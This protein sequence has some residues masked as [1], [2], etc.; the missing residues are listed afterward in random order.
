MIRTRL[1]SGLGLCL[2]FEVLA[3][4]PR[5]AFA[6]CTTV[7]PSPAVI[8]ATGGV[9]QWE[10]IQTNT[11]ITPEG[12]LEQGC[13]ITVIASLTIPVVSAADLS[14][15]DNYTGIPNSGFITETDPNITFP[16]TGYIYKVNVA[17]NLGPDRFL[18]VGAAFFDS[19]GITSIQ[20]G[21]VIQKGLGFDLSIA[22]ISISQ[23]NQLIAPDSSGTFPLSVGIEAAVTLQINGS[24][25][26]T[27][28]SRTTSV[29]FSVDGHT[30]GSIPL[31]LADL[32]NA[33]GAMKITVPAIP[34]GAG[35]QRWSAIV[36]PGNAQNE[37]D[38][39]NNLASTFVRVGSKYEV[40]AS[41]KGAEIISQGPPLLV[42]V[43]PSNLRVCSLNS[44]PFINE[45]LVN[46]KCNDKITGA[47]ISGCKFRVVGSYPSD[48]YDGGHDRL[49]HPARPLQLLYKE[50]QS[51]YQPIPVEGIDV[52]YF[53]PDASG[54]NDLKIYGKGPNGE[55]IEPFVIRIQVRTLGLEKISIAHL[56]FVNLVTHK[57]GTY[58]TIG[59]I[60]KLNVAI[61]NYR[62]V[63]SSESRTQ[64]NPRDLMSE[65]ANLPWG[66]LFDIGENHVAPN[67]AEPHCGHRGNNIDIS[68]SDLTLLERKALARAIKNA[69]MKTP[70]QPEA[71][72]S[73]DA[74]H[75]HLSE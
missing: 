65:G 67:W 3:V 73:A 8:P 32:R 64:M 6:G 34:T 37:S 12:T 55:S 46:I 1:F 56:G 53:V 75:W 21:T 7:S 25:I 26:P 27:T 23:S 11:H 45:K 63:V 15:L 61:E 33:G 13:G 42:R 10:G 39:S 49:N 47:A 24:N 38:F 22:L 4:A 14:S 18:Y 66:G 36:D 9:I 70:Y 30:V 31:S 59:L 52:R 69:G 29:A 48:A 74:G 50:F 68:V 35:V 62:A 28:E 54:E 16:D 60:E 19:N 40:L 5:L 20:Y 17:P 57:S 41:M 71:P 44:E 2:L 58:G 43:D 72:T 51:E